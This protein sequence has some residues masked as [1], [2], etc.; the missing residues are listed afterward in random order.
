VN[1]HWLQFSDFV[2]RYT[3]TFAATRLILWATKIH[4]NAFPARLCPELLQRSSYFL[5]GLESA[6]LLFGK[7]KGVKEKKERGKL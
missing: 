1:V 5:A 4:Q 3:T 2:D 6:G 7:E